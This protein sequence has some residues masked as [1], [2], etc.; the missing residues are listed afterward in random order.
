MPSSL[1][2][3]IVFSS[4]KLVASIATFCP[5]ISPSIA[6]LACPSWL[7]TLTA[8]APTVLSGATDAALALRRFTVSAV[9]STSPFSAFTMLPLP[10]IT[11]AVLLLSVTATAAAIKE[12]LGFVVV[13]EM[14]KF[15]VLATLSSA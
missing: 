2:A 9:I 13:E 15:A 4:I 1:L 7:N 5:V 6:I 14:F 8:A 12:E 3:V 11:S 10:I